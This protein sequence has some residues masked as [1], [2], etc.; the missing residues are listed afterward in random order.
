M[1][2]LCFI[3]AH[4]FFDAK[5]VSCIDIWV[6]KRGERGKGINFLHVERMGKEKG[7]GLFR[8]VKQGPPAVTLFS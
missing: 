2:F 1:I 3:N 6:E 7:S 4:V 8:S 5:L